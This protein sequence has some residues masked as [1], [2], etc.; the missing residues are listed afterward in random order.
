MKKGRDM[1]EEDTKE[2]AHY[3]HL[4]RESELN[5]NKN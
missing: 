4:L 1:I 2:Q 3:L 5:I